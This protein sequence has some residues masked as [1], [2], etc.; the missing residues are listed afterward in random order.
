M[1]KMNAVQK[2]TIS[3][4]TAILAV[5]SVCAMPSVTYAQSKLTDGEKCMK[6]VYRVGL[7]VA[8][9]P[10]VTSLTGI[11]N[12][13]VKLRI[14]NKLKAAGLVILSDSAVK[15]EKGKSAIYFGVGKMDFIAQEGEPNYFTLVGVLSFAQDVIPVRQK[16]L[17]INRGVWIS[18]P[19]TAN[20][21][22]TSSVET[23]ERFVFMLADTAVQDFLKSYRKANPKGR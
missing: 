22:N 2:A 14:G 23:R 5:I 6:G 9:T 10:E 13:D 15:Q 7:N 21:S 4:V 18:N 20:L 3:V 11:T 16:D 8:I 1:K 19:L 17:T 12:N